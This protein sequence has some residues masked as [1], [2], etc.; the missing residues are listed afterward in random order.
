MKLVSPD[1]ASVAIAVLQFFRPQLEC[2]SVFA[3]SYAYGLKVN[4]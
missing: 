1:Q 2:E 3:E 4:Q